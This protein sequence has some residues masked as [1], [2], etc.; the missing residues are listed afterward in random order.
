[1]DALQS[2][3]VWNRACRLAVDTYQAL[4]ACTD[5]VFRDHVTRASLAVPTRIADGYERRSRPQFAQHLRGAHG[6][7][8]EIRTQLY[9]AADIGLLETAT[10]HRL[11]AEALHIAKQLQ[12]LIDRCEHNGHD[13]EPTN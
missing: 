3:A 4:A 12:V 8:A 13:R 6:A 11:I 5:S 2:L 1:M 10:A 7:C 9:I